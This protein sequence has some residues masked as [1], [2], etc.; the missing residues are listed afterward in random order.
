MRMGPPSPKAK[1]PRPM[2][3]RRG[4]VL[5]G[6]VLGM[7]GLF[8]ARWFNLTAQL[9]N[10]SLSVSDAHHAALSGALTLIDIRRP[11][12]WASTGI[13][14][15][16]YPLD[17]RRTDFIKTLTTIVSDRDAPIALICARGVRSNAMAKRLNE[18][19]FSHIIDVP[20]GMLGSGAGPGWLKTGL[21]IRKP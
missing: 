8:A 19:G 17:M 3:S 7:G 16:A 20:E 14:E 5:G 13:G 18:A 12:E 10:N 6:V 11:D 1:L 4:L 2:V 21:P 9:D 15:A